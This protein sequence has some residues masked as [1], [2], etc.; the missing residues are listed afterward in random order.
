[1][2][3]AEAGSGDAGC[4]VLSAELAE[5]SLDDVETLLSDGDGALGRSETAASCAPSLLTALQAGERLGFITNNSSET[6]EACAAELRRK[7]LGLAYC[8]A[9]HLLQRRAGAPGPKPACWAAQPWARSWRTRAWGPSR[10]R[11][12]LPGAWLYAPPEPKVCAVE[13]GFYQPFSSMKLP[14]AVRFLQQPYRLLVSTDL[15]HRLPLENSRFLAGTGWAV[16]SG[17]W[18]RH[19]APSPAAS[20]ATAGS[21][22]VAS[23]GSAPSW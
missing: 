4:V 18:R 15:D 3:K 17:P 13:M 14:K 20:S 2:Q 6:L 5:A 8:T 1:M 19:P 16:S 22:S 9:L 7:V 11:V 12:N 23:S 21:R 10:C